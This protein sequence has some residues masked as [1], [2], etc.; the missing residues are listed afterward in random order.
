MFKLG[1]RVKILA[2]GE[3]GIVKAI[4]KFTDGH[5][6]YEVKKILF[7]HYELALI[8]RPQQTNKRG[9]QATYIPKEPNWTI[10]DIDQRRADRLAQFRQRRRWQ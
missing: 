8:G 9:R 10:E 4:A 7:H 6:L 5:Q 3:T 2:T 1:D